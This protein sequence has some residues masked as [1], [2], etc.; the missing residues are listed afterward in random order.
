[1]PSSMSMPRTRS[2]HP[3]R[4]SSSTVV[5]AMGLGRRGERVANTPCEMGEALDVGESGFELRQDVEFTL[6]VMLCAKAFRNLA[7]LGV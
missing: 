6:G 1:M 3:S 4:P 2:L 5:R 7:G